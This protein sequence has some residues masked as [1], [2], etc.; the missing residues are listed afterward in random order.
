MS[1]YTNAEHLAQVS[2]VQRD[3]LKETLAGL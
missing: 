1:L 3:W 2:R